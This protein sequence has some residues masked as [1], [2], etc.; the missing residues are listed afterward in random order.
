M[1]LTCVMFFF[2]LENHNEFSALESG[3]KN[4]TILLVTYHS[5]CMISTIRC[6][7]NIYVDCLNPCLG[8]HLKTGIA[9]AQLHVRR[10]TRLHTPTILSS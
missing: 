7:D 8:I 5:W 10:C 1:M 9:F 4:P 6:T 2:H 3:N